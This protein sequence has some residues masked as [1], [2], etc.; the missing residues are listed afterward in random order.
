MPLTESAIEST[1]E[2]LKRSPGTFQRLV[3]R[4][5][6]LTYPHRFKH[7]VPQGRNP[8]DVTVKGWPDVYA[9]SPDGR[10]DVAEATHSPA[11]PDHHSLMIRCSSSLTTYI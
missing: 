11:W 7:L 1:M 4:Y 2:G 6:Y 10:M 8:H 9:L 5:A 3:E